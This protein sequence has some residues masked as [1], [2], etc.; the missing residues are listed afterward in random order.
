MLGIVY[1]AISGHLI[2]KEPPQ[3]LEQGRDY[4]ELVKRDGR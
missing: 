3:F 2:R 1:R 4:S